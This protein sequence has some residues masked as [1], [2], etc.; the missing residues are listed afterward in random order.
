MAT[1]VLDKALE[2]LE[3]RTGLVKPVIHMLLHPVPGKSTW[4]YVFGT[5][6]MTSFVVQLASGVALST[7]YVPSGGEAWESIKW[8]TEKV[9]FGSWLRATHYFGASAMIIFVGCH[10]I[11]TYLFGS[12]KFPRELNWITG[13][14]LLFLTVAIAFTGQ[15]LRWDQTAVWTVAVGA[16]Q[17]LRAPILGPTLV[18]ILCS[19]DNVS[20]ASLSHFFAMHVFI[21]PAILVALIGFHVWLV[22]HHGIS[23]PPKAGKPVNR[24]TYR[25][26]YQELLKKEGK[27][28]WPDAFWR[29]AVFSTIVVLGICACA[30]YFGPPAIENPPDPSLVNAEPKPDWY[31][32]WY[33]ALLALVPAP[34]EDWFILLFPLFLVFGM[35]LPPFVSNTGERSA[36]R[37][38]WAVAIVV[39]VVGSVLALWQEGINEYWTPKFEATP[40]PPK[41]VATM[42]TT[43]EK[44]AKVFNDRGCLFCHMIAGHG[45]RRGPDL[46]DVGE[47][48]T[49]D[50]LI[51][52]IV[53]GGVN[54]PAYAGNITP[55]E[56]A[57]VTKFLETRRPHALPGEPPAAEKNSVDEKNPAAVNVENKAATES[58]QNSESR[59]QESSVASGNQSPTEVPKNEILPSEQP[60][61][62]IEISKTEIA[63]VRDIAQDGMTEVLLGKL[64]EKKATAP[65][66]KAMAT[67]MVTEHTAA[68]EQ[69][70]LAAKSV[71]MTLPP[72]VSDQQKALIDSLSKL[73]GKEF[74]TKYVSVLVEAHAN[75]I[76]V[77]DTEV[78]EGTGDLKSWAQGAL[79]AIKRHHHQAM[80]LTKL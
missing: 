61:P 17:A 20:A 78:K 71:G 39:V 54:M 11:R 33:F 70:K 63:R 16:E 76:S 43:I 1:K 65:E 5:A 29:D 41:A 37:R 53:N 59:K 18:R 23:E 22:L 80:G 74:D 58:S 45:G 79:V 55:Q 24:D 25:E 32:T 62:K 31:L 48:L 38:P 4:A 8:I 50:Q 10:A 30:L 34:I 13:V 3:D 36:R 19:G 28:F 68:N 46:T 35:L 49:H 9:P 26:E 47:R 75:A 77:I 40:V 44:G 2:W 12:F 56:L 60:L 73:S 14:F 6:I 7:M 42:N 67:Q 51:V 64:A 69:L 72:N 27:P 66:V 52:R 21:F 57:E 15:V